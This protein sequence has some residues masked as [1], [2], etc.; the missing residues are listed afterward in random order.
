MTNSNIDLTEFHDRVVLIT[1]GG[2]PIAQSID[3]AEGLNEVCG[4]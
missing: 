4:E 1:V 2:P 3:L